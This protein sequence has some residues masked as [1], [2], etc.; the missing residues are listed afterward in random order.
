MGIKGIPIQYG[1]PNAAAH[2]E[3]LIGTLKRECFGHFIF[4][5]ES[6]LLRTSKEFV[7]YYSEGAQT[8]SVLLNRR[9]EVRRCKGTGRDTVP[10]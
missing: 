3:R 5:S 2:V 7:G 8:S 6:H 10:W 1:A 4:F 9:A